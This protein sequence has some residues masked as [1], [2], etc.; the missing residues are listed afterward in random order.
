VALNPN[1]AERH[2]YLA[3]TFS[4]AGR[5][6]EAL[7]EMEAALR[8]SPLTSSEAKYTAGRIHYQAEQYE[9]AISFFRV[10][11]D[12]NPT[13][14][15]TRMFLAASYAGAGQLA[16]ARAAFAEIFKITPKRPVSLWV[17]RWSGFKT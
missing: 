14:I 15:S 17:E 13:N 10:L 2:L 7:V 4:L 16:E 8:L 12:R 11:V 6:K 1:G 3:D 5:S 9:K